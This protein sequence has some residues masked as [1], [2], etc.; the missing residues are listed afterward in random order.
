MKVTRKEEIVQLFFGLAWLGSS[1]DVNREA[2]NGRGGVDFKISK[3]SADKTLIE[4]KLAS[5]T[6]LE[7]N[8]QKQLEIY[9]EANR[10]SYG[11]KVIFTTSELEAKKVEG[12]INRLQ[13]N[14][15]KDVVVIDARDDNK[16]SA[17]T[18]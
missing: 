14:D 11:I 2:N 8:L 7:K 5:N 4:F 17:S 6:A 3:G 12:I 13:L 18:A 16:P 9:K 15:K 1:Y 10:T